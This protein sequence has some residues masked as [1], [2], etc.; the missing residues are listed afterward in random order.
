MGKIKGC[1]NDSCKAHK[2]KIIY[3]ESE[4]FCST[5]G[6]PLVYVCKDCYTQILKKDTKYCVRCLAKQEDRKDKNKKMAVKIGGGALTVG[7]GILTLG[8]K[9][10]DIAKKIKG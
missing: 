9:A 3:K 8:K 1:S 2:K 6:S 5:C 7:V 10:I 4:G